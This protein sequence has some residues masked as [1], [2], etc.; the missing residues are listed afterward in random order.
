MAQAAVDIKEACPLREVLDWRDWGAAWVVSSGILEGETTLQRPHH[1]C[2]TGQAMSMSCATKSFGIRLVMA[3]ACWIGA[4]CSARFA[5]ETQVESERQSSADSV[6]TV[7]GQVERR[8]PAGRS[9]DQAERGETLG[10]LSQQA[11]QVRLGL[12]DTIRLER[13]PVRDADLGLLRGLDRLRALFLDQ[14]EVT[15]TGLAIL[16]NL[17]QLEQVRIRGGRIGDQGLVQLS[18]C[19]RLRFLNLPQGQFS[20]AGLAALTDLPQL[21]LLRFGSPH[22]TDA[23]MVHL[24]AMPRLRFLHLIAVPLTDRGLAR[25][26]QC[27]RL[28]SCYLDDIVLSDEAVEAL[29]I[30]RPQLHL[31]VDQEHHDRDPQRDHHQKTAQ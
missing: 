26:G 10:S 30:A 1:A 9:D 15:D 3:T 5:S 20:D 17:P 31:H 23:G 13:T 16:G 24:Q 14:S 21:E 12:S 4:S 28:E 27:E 7:P 25:I 2:R 18:R 6:T 29:L 19:S 8:T 22:V 11:Q